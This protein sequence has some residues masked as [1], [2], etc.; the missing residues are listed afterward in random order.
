VLGFTPD[1]YAEEKYT[2]FQELI[3]NLNQFDVD[4]FTRMIESGGNK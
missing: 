2:Q 3:G 4:V 1:N